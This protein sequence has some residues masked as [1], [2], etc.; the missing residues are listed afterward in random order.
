MAGTR[1]KF[2]P[3]GGA[4]GRSS[5]PAARAM[6]TR[7]AAVGAVADV[8]D[9]G[10]PP[11]AAE[12]DD[13][14]HDGRRPAA[15]R[16]PGPLTYP[17]TSSL[18]SLTSPA[19]SPVGHVRATPPGHG[20]SSPPSPGGTSSSSSA[21][22]LRSWRRVRDHPTRR[23]SFPLEG[24]GHVLGGDEVRMVDGTPV[25]GRVVGIDGPYPDRS[26]SRVGER[27]GP[28]TVNDD[29]LDA[30]EEE[31]VRAE[32]A[33]RRALLAETEAA[34]DPTS[35]SSPD[36]DRGGGED[37]RHP[38]RDQSASDGHEYGA[39]RTPLD[40][41]VGSL[42]DKWRLVPH[43]LKLRGLMKQHIDSYDHF[44]GVE[45]KQ[46]VQVRGGG[47]HFRGILGCRLL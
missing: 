40:A 12:D 39:P 27:G 21:A 19:P 45:M 10:D 13:D 4:P 34:M 43:F 33:A 1:K 20:L 15:P 31:A 9:E 22:E 28:A 3:T 17:S 44:I 36:P 24:F 46:I 30:D 26:R 35:A 8:K 29:D 32:L 14:E 25:G 23:G 6:P 11:G 47:K 5:R 41:P 18:P 2:R 42:R 38:R 37:E 16:R 7:I